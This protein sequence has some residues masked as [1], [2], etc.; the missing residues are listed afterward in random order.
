M[1]CWIPAFQVV[2]EGEQEHNKYEDK[3]VPCLRE[4]HVLE[5]LDTPSSFIYSLE[6]DPVTKTALM[7]RSTTMTATVQFVS[8]GFEGMQSCTR[9]RQLTRPAASHPSWYQHSA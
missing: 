6:T 1:M 7:V 2:C 4:V 8:A 5:A 9:A 3:V